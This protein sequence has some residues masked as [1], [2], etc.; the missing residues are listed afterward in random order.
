MNCNFKNYFIAIKILNKIDFR[1]KINLNLKKRIKNKKIAKK[2]I[3][4]KFWNLINNVK[5]FYNNNSLLIRETNLK[6]NK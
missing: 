5:N 4:L 1:N 6:W 2:K 3:N